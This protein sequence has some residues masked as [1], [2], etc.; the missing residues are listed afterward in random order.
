MEISFN[1]H[2]FPTHFIVASIQERPK[3]KRLTKEG[4]K[5]SNLDAEHLPV[6]FDCF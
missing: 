5:A 2:T 4:A 3:K 1:A 6:V